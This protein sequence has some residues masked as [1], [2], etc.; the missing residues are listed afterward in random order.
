MTGHRSF[1]ELRK[2]M[3]SERRARNAEA[4]KQVL[5]ETA[6]HELLPTGERSRDEFTRKLKVEQPGAAAQKGKA[7]R[8]PRRR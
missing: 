2:R 1:A 5:A 8:V 3:S 4:T 6:L 7:C